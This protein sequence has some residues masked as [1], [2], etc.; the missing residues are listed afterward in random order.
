M[1]KFWTYFG[2]F[3][4]R[5][6]NLFAC[7]WPNIEKIDSYLVTIIISMTSDQISFEKWLPNSRKN[8][9]I[10]FLGSMNKSIF[11]WTFYNILFA[12]QT[13]KKLP[14]RDSNSRHNHYQ[15]STYFVLIS[16]FCQCDQI[17]L[18]LKTAIALFWTHC[19]CCKWPNIEQIIYPCGH[20]IWY[21]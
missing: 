16:R 4:M 2:K 14:D 11:W 10:Y 15:E 5:L 18:H 6:G 21:S 20:T 12:R 3:C 8:V 17:G 19:Q 7:K 9:S 1:S 13:N